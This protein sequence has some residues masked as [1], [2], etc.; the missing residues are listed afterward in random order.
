V[1][2]RRGGVIV[3]SGHGRDGVLLAPLT[4]DLVADLLTGGRGPGH[5]ELLSAC[6]PAR[7]DRVEVPA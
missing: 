1:I 3:A 5:T 6:D 2:G 4:G 7:F